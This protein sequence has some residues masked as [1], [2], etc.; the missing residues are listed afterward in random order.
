ML[1]RKVKAQ[2]QSWLDSSPNKALLVKGARQ[3][4]KSFLVNAFANIGVQGVQTR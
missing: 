3:V 1:D 2:F 4:G